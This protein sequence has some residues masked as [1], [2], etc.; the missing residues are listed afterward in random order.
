MSDQLGLVDR[1]H[2][3]QREEALRLVCWQWVLLV[4]IFL[5]SLNDDFRSAGESIIAY[6]YNMH[7]CAFV[8][9]DAREREIGRA[10]ILC[11]CLFTC[12]C[13][14]VCVCVCRVGQTTGVHYTTKKQPQQHLSLQPVSQSCHIHKN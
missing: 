12:L 3:S 11:V 10:Y 7:M 6:D 14:C 2:L 4:L 5:L 1:K 13:V 8:C 9:R